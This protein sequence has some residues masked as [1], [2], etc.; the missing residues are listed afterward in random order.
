MNEMETRSE[1]TGTTYNKV[2]N[3]RGDFL[4]T[5]DKLQIEK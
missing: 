4:M 5:L 3:I 1:S 2:E